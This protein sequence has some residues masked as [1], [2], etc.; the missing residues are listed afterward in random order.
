MKDFK[1][2]GIWPFNSDLFTGADFQGAS[3][4]DRLIKDEGEINYIYDISSPSTFNVA[5]LNFAEANFSS[6][7]IVSSLQ[8]TDV[9][10]F[11]KNLAMITLI[12]K[13]STTAG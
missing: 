5:G 8:N 12:H 9:R 4:I 11:G 13:I 1:R 7:F 6:M 10:Y 2:T 3:V